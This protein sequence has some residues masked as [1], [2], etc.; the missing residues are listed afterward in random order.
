MLAAERFT[1]F[2]SIDR[3]ARHHQDRLVKLLSGAA[4]SRLIK[5]I[6]Q[7]TVQQAHAGRRP[8]EMSYPHD[9]KLEG[10]IAEIIGVV[11]KQAREQVKQ[12]LQR[13]KGNKRGG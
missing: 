10:Q 3:M 1:D 4:K 8:S 9:H 13:Q 6:A 2:R 11:Y 12:E 7:Q 5:A